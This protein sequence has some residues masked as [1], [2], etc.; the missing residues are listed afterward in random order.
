VRKAID[1][2][3]KAE[4]V[5]NSKEATA[6]KAEKKSDEKAPQYRDEAVKATADFKLLDEQVM[7][8]LRSW[9]QV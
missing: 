6:E 5:M 4:K 3:D 7:S 8:R 9:T 2:R 1:E